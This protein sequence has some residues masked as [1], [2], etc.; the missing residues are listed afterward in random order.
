[1]PPSKHRDDQLFSGPVT[2]ER[3][4]AM[5][6]SQTVAGDQTVS[7][8]LKVD[9]NQLPS[10]T[11]NSSG[12]ALDVSAVTEAALTS[13]QVR[14]GRHARLTLTDL[15]IAV[16]AALDYGGEKICDLPDSNILIL[17]A[18]VDLS[19]VKDGVGIVDAT[20]VTVGIGTAVA[21]NATLSGAMI[22]VLTDAL[23]DDV[24]PALFKQ[25]TH[26]LGTPALTFIDDGAAAALFLN[27]VATLSA[28]G[29]P[30]VS[31]TVD[32]YYIDTGNVTS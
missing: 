28:D 4:V 27:A 29:D 15:V 17:G 10:A 31:G 19:L 8:D 24:D 6:S 20:D 13:D 11:G 30:T 12:G 21:S 18:E 1:M 16:T 2:F 3:E 25:H 7:G 32:I 23:T 5:R 26:D 9:G 22:D 14:Y